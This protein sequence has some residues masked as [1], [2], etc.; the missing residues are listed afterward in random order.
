MVWQR[1]IQ[2]L[3]GRNRR[4]TVERSRRRALKLET[5]T[6][7]QL[8][9]SDI[10]AVSGIAY[11]DL[12][13][14][15]LTGDDTRLEGITVELYNDTNA[16]NVYDSGVDTLAATTTTA[17]S[18]DPEPGLYRFDNLSVGTYFVLQGSAGAGVTTPAA[19]LVD[20]TADDADG[21]TIVTIDD[22]TTGG[23]L[24]T[25]SGNTTQTNTQA[26]ANAL[27][28]SR[29]VELVHTNASGNTTFQVD[30]G[31]E[32]LSLS[33]G[34]G[35]L[36]QAT[37]EYDGNDGAYG[38][39]FVPGLSPAA[40]LAGGAAGTTPAINTG[41]EI[42]A[43]AEN[44]DETMTVI[45]FTSATEASQIDIT[46]PQNP[47]LQTIFVDFTNVGWATSGFAGVTNPADF[48]NV[49]AI[50][51]TATV[52]L[53]DNDIFFS[54]VES[55]GPSP[56]E[57]NLSN[58]QLLQLGGTVFEDLGGGT[59]SNN[60]TLD[61]TESGMQNVTVEL[62]AEPGGGGAIDPSTQT[63]VATTTT[64][65]NGD[66]VFTDLDAGNYM[67][68]IP[69]AQFGSGQPFFG[70]A[71]STGND[72]SPDP[73]DDIDNDDNGAISAGVGI[74]SQEITL[75]A[76]SEPNND[77]DTDVNTNFTLDFG[78]TPT[79]DLEITKT[80]DEPASTLN[81]GGQAFF[82]IDF[83]N[84]GPLD[85][86]N[87]VITDSIPVG[88]T[89]NQ[90][91]S[92]FGGFTPTIVGQ[93]ITI[94][95]GTLAASATGSIRIAVD[96]DAGQTAPLTNTATIAG[97]EVETDD[98]NNSD[99]ALATLAQ[100]DLVIT[101]SDNTTGSVTA[102]EQFTYTITV[103]NDGPDTA[104]GIVVTD[105]L[106]A[107]LSFVSG[108]FTS[109]S[110]T[111]TESPA[112]SG[113]L[114]IN[115]DDL[116]DAASATIDLIVMVAADAGTSLTNTATVAGS[117][118][119]DPDTSNN[120]AT[121]TTPVAR[122]VDVG[123]TKTTT[124]TAV[125]GDSIT[126]TFT[127]TNSGPS[128]ARDVEVTDTLAAA[129]TFDSF[130]AG[131]SGVTVSQNG[132]D[133]TFDV[134]TLTSGQTETFTVTVDI[135]SSATGTLN[136]QADIT[137]SDTDTNAANDSDDI[138][139]TINR[140]TDLIL[141]K[142]VDL[143]TATPG[144]D[145]LTYTFT[146]SHDTDSISDSAQVTFTDLLPAG[147]TLGQISA[148]G[149]ASQGFDSTSRT[150]TVVFDTIAIGATETF[151]M[152][153]TVDEDATGTIDNDASISVAGGDIDTTN[154]SDDA[155]TTLSPEF[156]VTIDKTADDTT[157][158]SG[159]NVTYTIDLTNAGPS[160]ATG[161]ILTDAIP[162][163]MTFVSGT[164]DGQSATSNGTTVTFPAVT[165]A[166]AETKSATLVFTVGA[167]ENG[168]I[169]N[170]ASVTADA[171]ETNTNNNSDSVDVTATPQTDLTVDKTVD[172]STAQ[173]GDT[174]VY[175]IT[176]TNDGVSTA[177]DVTAVDTLP[178]GLTFVSANT[179]GNETVTTNGQTVTVDVG[180]LAASGTFTFTINATV[181]ATAPSTVTNSVSVETVTGESDLTN[182]SDTA[183]TTV[184]GFQ[185]SISGSVYVDANDNGVRDSGEVGIAGVTITLTGTNIFN[186]PV[187]R[188]VTTDDNG[189]YL[190]T[191]LAAGTYDVSETQPEDYIDGQDT[192]G[193]GATATVDPDAFS[194]LTFDDSPGAA[195]DFNFGESAA[196]L[197]KRR[198]LA[199]S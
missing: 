56:I 13:G 44:Q 45:V 59:D 35:A 147:L 120:T 124:D 144:D 174:L 166:D 115:V 89:I 25:A 108:S 65:V 80:L 32:L 70:Y 153:A 10:G 48:N 29:D 198:F 123:V 171:G 164:L 82:D 107:D 105:N 197:S 31:T 52:T 47:A 86:N 137:T 60:G 93:D 199:S 141:T 5:L 40:Q 61:G 2:R 53:A 118:D 73:D 138:D 149:A 95:V 57:V 71:T 132:Q 15:G 169:T 158:A 130:D 183:A 175:T 69:D 178:S 8:L 106:P 114:T 33:T 154:D 148:P 110:G 58:T 121:E 152:T 192:L 128:D 39:S 139:L 170:T 76:G 38:L 161:V 173:A 145:T 177:E 37:V 79:I 195:V 189:D 109:G 19:A 81:A 162:T 46:I 163:G 196:V 77:G 36:S 143:S 182:N 11:A 4:A 179:P 92:N 131:T 151:T 142:T 41:I 14:D 17:T 84:N 159:T 88:M 129:L 157:P 155:Q 1:M 22:F 126:Y 168:T 24:I 68:V 185:S 122:N 3:T 193:T 100:A 9:A 127:V 30:N 102:G 49:A 176:V 85:A 27:G 62:Y 99:S 186:E 181:D 134:G 133:L 97:D 94:P 101:K 167:T 42:Q 190:F 172:Q 91:A 146:I 67:V 18:A 112:S 184:E 6:K 103:T 125:A 64:D 150:V 180:D 116:A 188:V 96:I 87:V 16:N 43:R 75:V 78:L 20:V 26:A 113:Q 191:Q 34:G 63:A 117:P 23:Q 54:V 160:T 111:V 140:T 50:R 74:V 72:P 12:T 194:D 55:R 165:L 7:R 119:I 51:A 187:T 90:G 21:E 156:D 136:N 66:Y 135:A 104:T 83:G 98:T 28:G